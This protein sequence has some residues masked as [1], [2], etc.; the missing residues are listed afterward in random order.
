MLTFQNVCTHLTDASAKLIF[1]VRHAEGTHNAAAARDRALFMEKLFDSP[2]F[3][4]APLTPRGIEQCARLKT[5]IDAVGADVELIVV[6]PLTRTLQTGSLSFGAAYPS[7][8]M[9]AS[10]SC[11]ERIAVY[12]SEGR[13][14]LSE[15]K[16]AWPKVDFSQLTSEQDPMFADKEEDSVVAARALHFMNWVMALPE[17]RIA[18]VTHSVF[19]QV[20]QP[21]ERRGIY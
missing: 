11:R 1:F 6:S 20:R 10:E 7:V 14:N 19:L 18:V 9:L 13:A 12:T 17:R 3:W 8:R 15:L 16:K 4:D 5:E 21:R 2:T